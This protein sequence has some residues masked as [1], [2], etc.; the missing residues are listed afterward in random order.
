MK[1]KAS[2]VTL[3][4]VCLLTTFPLKVWAE[5]ILEKV[6][7]TGILTVGA[8]KDA[9][10]FGFVD[11][12]G[13]WQ[14]YSVDLLHLI[15]HELEKKLGKSIKLEM[16]A[17]TIN[18]RFDAV[19]D[20]KVDIV[21][22]ATTITQERLE[23]VDFSVPFFMTGTQFLVKTGNINQ[24][25]LNS[26]LK[27]QKIAYIPNTTT[28]IIIRQ[29]YP[30]AHWVSVRDRQEGLKKLNQDQVIAVASDGILLIAEVVAEGKDPDDYA[31]T[32]RVPMTTELYACILPQNESS[33]KQ[34]VDETIA[35]SQNRQLQEKW[36]N[37]L[38]GSFPYVIRIEP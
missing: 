16:E 23:K 6:E 8:R 17:V 33:W 4:T 22:G 15:H 20:K 18:E 14:G 31:L 29:V 19:K 26:T 7:K 30:F 37:A 9:V 24:F 27:E 1:L 28:D 38:Q 13:K 3:L 35:G 25:N 5:T 34:F 10:P 32:P 21:C 12:D 11:T 36:F 2:A